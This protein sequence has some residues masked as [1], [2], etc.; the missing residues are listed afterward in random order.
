MKKLLILSIF[1]IATF[2]KAHSDILKDVK[3]TNNERI[4]KET[5]ITYGQIEIGSAYD[6]NKL[7]KLLKIYMKLISSK[8]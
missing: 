5:I 2:T 4:S 3:I 8:I 1:F 7:N 6:D